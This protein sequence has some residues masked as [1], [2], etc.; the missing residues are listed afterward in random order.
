MLRYRYTL[1]NDGE[2]RVTK[3]EFYLQKT[4]KYRGYTEKI[5]R[6]LYSSDPLTIAEISWHTGIDKRS[7]N[8]VLTFNLMAG[9]IQRLE[10]L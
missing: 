5:F 9:Y 6:A 3:N 4:P 7:V 2:R 8:G 1:T 10:L